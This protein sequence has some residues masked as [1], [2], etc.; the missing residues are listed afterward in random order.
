MPAFL[1][2]RTAAL[3][4]VIAALLAL[5]VAQAA[6]AAPLI[7][8]VHT[9]GSFEIPCPSGGVLIGTFVEDDRIIT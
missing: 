1:Q 7:D 5:P 3:L 6:A 8:E 2:F 9:E 4:A